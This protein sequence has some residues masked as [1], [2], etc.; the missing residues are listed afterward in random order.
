MHPLQFYFSRCSCTLRR[1]A[2]GGGR[3]PAPAVTSQ[4]R[5]T[6][7][8]SGLFVK[9]SRAGLL[10]AV[11]GAA[12]R[13]FFFFLSPGVANGLA[14]PADEVDLHSNAPAKRKTHRREMILL[15]DYSGGPQ[16][17]EFTDHVDEDTSTEPGQLRHFS[18]A[19]QEGLFI[20]KTQWALPSPRS[21]FRR[22]WNRFRRQKPRSR[23]KGGAGLLKEE[24]QNDHPAGDACTADLDGA[25]S[26]VAPRRKS[27]R[28][29]PLRTEPVELL[30]YEIPARRPML[31]VNATRA[32]D[33]FD[34]ELPDVVGNSG[35]TP[36]HKSFTLAKL[37][38][39]IYFGTP[40][41]LLAL[42]QNTNN[43]TYQMNLRTISGHADLRPRVYGLNKDNFLVRELLNQKQSTK[44]KNEY[45]SVESESEHQEEDGG[46]DS[47]LVEDEPDYHKPLVVLV[48][49]HVKYAF[50]RLST[51]PEEY[52]MR[53]LLEV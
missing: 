21:F 36:N 5:L 12:G 3:A 11:F 29:E 40:R 14:R 37:L 43:Y 1:P 32:L 39:R 16:G 19:N 22:M 45:D 15:D 25:K 33:F 49:D 27:R 42:D 31:L 52:I 2:A 41:N 48:H 47:K 17:Q 35:W 34:R 7:Y 51:D 44:Y 30:D 4:L 26:S 9:M 6:S 23:N 53:R 20:Q 13:L 38:N 18:V 28:P 24:V 8:G 10:F 46:C 50:Q